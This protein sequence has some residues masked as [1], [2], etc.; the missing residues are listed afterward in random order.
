MWDPN[1]TEGREAL[2]QYRRTLLRGL[3]AAARK[4]TNFGKISEVIQG[5]E[6]SPAAFLERLLEAYRIYTPL[7][8][9]AIEN[10]RIVNIAFVT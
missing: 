3:K 2:L 9:E 10:Q 7:N 6:E 1:T 4:P 5:R 8:P